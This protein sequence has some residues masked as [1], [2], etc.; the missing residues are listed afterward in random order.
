MSLQYIGAVF[1]EDKQAFLDDT[2]NAIR[3]YILGTG[4]QCIAIIEKIPNGYD[5]DK[6][7]QYRLYMHRTQFESEYAEVL[8]KFMRRK[9]YDGHELDSALTQPIL[10]I[11]E[12]KYVALY[13]KHGE[14]ISAEFLKM[15]RN[16]DVLLN[17]F[18]KRLG[19]K[20]VNKLSKE[21][22]SRVIH[23]IVDQIKNASSSNTSHIVSH[24]VSH[25]AASAV[26]T[27]VAHGAAQVLLHV[28]ATNIGHIIAKFLA[29][30]A[31]KKLMVALLHKFIWNVITAMV[32]KFLAVHIG[33]TLGAS[34]FM[35]IVIPIAIAILLKQINDFPKKL[36][37]EV[38][39]SVR[40]HLADSFEETN[41]DILKATFEEV[42]N[43]EQLL[44]AVANDKSVK[45]MVD[46]VA[47][48]IVGVR[49]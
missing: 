13:Q 49:W 17:S 46:K 21:A 39:A 40:S 33:A 1:D 27:Q 16:D 5:E 42:I 36:S 31:F 20:L 15:L 34:A 2:Q 38:S 45:D 12:E 22:R 48:E 29:S 47:S 24:H 23:L 26:G 7:P 35:W 3:S 41:R 4:K 10:E 9:R 30:A 6:T 28:L 44:L 14:Q 43:G 25:F 11:I 32:V 19:D 8:I 18:V 37:V